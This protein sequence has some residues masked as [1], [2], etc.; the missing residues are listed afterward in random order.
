MVQLEGTYKD[1]QNHTSLGLT[2][3]QSMLLRS[4]S[5]WLL[6]AFALVE[7]HVTSDHTMVQST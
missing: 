2:K 3:S 7:F 6:N 4:L 1:G 5:K